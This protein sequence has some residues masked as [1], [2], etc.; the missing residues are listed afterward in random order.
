[1]QPTISFEVWVIILLF[2]TIL[3][4]AL[5][6]VY[7]RKKVVSDED[8][9]YV[10]AL[11]FMAEGENRHAVEKFK[12][13]V[14]DNSSNIDAYL[15]LG[16]ILRN[17]GLY[18][19]AIRI[20]QDLTLRGNLGPAELIDVKKN[21]ILDY[22][23]LKDYTK[24]E[25][26]LNQLKDDKN[27]IDWVAPYLVK[28]LEKKGE[29]QEA[30]EILNK[31]SLA[32]EQKGKYKIAALKVKQGQKLASEQEEKDARILFKEAIKIDHE[33][34]EG[35][36]QLGDSYLREGRTT[37]AINAWTDLCKKVPNK[38]HLAF[39]RLEK[40]WFEKGQFSK[41]EE[42]YLSM[43]QEDENNLPAIIAL[44]E[45]YRKKGDY[46]QSL[47]LL[48]EAQ[49]RDLDSDLIPSQIA[50]VRMDKGQYKEAATLALELLSKEIRIEGLKSD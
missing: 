2:G 31:S 26:Y 43:L 27:L 50:K 29:W 25:Y 46:D 20:H 4:M 7:A 28:I 6:T 5:Y 9:P 22:W 16:T 14:R 47:K 36:L 10:M 1:M 35:Y 19:N 38:A 40:A 17:E 8:K 42:L 30:V 34:A 24:A 48:Q 12:E 3:V 49:K 21:L 37:D 39:D 11:K 13:A 45:I 15:K 41:I 23:Y 32:R 44:S 33:C 18:K